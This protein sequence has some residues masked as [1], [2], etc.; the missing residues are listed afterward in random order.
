MKRLFFVLL[1][2]V[3]GLYF[4]GCEKQPITPPEDG[5]EVDQTVEKLAPIGWSA[6][7]IVASSKE[8]KE[9]TNISQYLEDQGDNGLSGIG[10]LKSQAMGLSKSASVE[11]QNYAGL[12]KVLSD[13][14]LFFKDDTVKGVRKALI[15]DA[16]TGL[17][18]Y[19]E[20]KYKFADW[21]QLVYDS[22]EV[23]LDLK[24]SPDDSL[25][26]AILGFYQLQLFKQS[27]FVQKI[28]NDVVVTDNVGL[29]I[30]G[31]EA[32]RNAYYRSD[33]HLVHLI[34]FVDLNPD[35]SGTL[36]EDFEFKDGKT[37]YR[38][39]T[40]YPDNSG[41]FAHKLR[42]GTMITGKFNGVE[43]DG[44]GY[45]EEF[46][47]LPPGRYIDTIEKF[48][49]VTLTLPDSIYTINLK[50]TVTFSSGLA[51]TDTAGIVTQTQ[52]G[53]TNTTINYSKH[54]G[55][56]GT[57]HVV[58]NEAGST[59]D[60]NWTTVEGFY[61]VLTAEYYFDSSGHVHF[62]VYTNEDAYN[63]GDAPIIVADYNFYPDGSGTGTLTHNGKSYN[64][65][66]S[67]SGEAE[68]FADGKSTTINLY[69]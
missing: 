34:Q 12:M 46:T 20:V 53:V 15:Y 52:F 24:H 54:N 47:Q 28:T 1:I 56:H 5:L 30:T 59:V 57:L 25:D 49:T 63:N 64:I 22:S 26:D 3:L 61:I 42:D 31:F 19:Y 60:G 10:L 58:E 4:G 7:R 23:K 65:S 9:V 14:V 67:E 37:A 41:E 6:N 33:R 66:F 39:V 62:E 35:K 51:I 16:E 40:F 45:Y 69:Q 50:E 13:S 18:R 38:S 21:R 36:R 68:I 27:F 32:T 2:G 43:D 8:I 11:S 48:A 17:A 55:E 44:E 29:K